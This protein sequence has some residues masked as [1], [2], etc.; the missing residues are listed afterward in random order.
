MLKNN[1]KNVEER[2]TFIARSTQNKTID[3]WAIAIRVSDVGLYTVN[4]LYRIIHSDGEGIAH[5]MQDL[6]KKNLA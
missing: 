1:W 3:V 5:T 2:L 6:Q 4:Q